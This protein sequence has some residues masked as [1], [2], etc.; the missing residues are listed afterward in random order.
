MIIHFE[1][2]MKEDFLQSFSR[3]YNWDFWSWEDY[4]H[5]YKRVYRET[6]WFLMWTGGPGR[7]LLV[8][9]KGIAQWSI[10]LPSKKTS[11]AQ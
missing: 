3:D 1:K 4:R 2:K 6:G 5:D 8:C 10:S 11:P 7:G 9:K